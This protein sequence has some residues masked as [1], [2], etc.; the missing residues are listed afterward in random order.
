MKRKYP[1]SS[2]SILSYDGAAN[3]IGTLTNSKH[4]F[5]IKD[6]KTMVEIWSKFVL[7]QRAP[8]NSNSFSDLY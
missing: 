2:P 8:I 4:L 3:I 1:G 5:S 6:I 7:G